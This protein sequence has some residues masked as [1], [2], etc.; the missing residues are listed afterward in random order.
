MSKKEGSTAERDLVVTKWIGLA[1]TGCIASNRQ[2]ELENRYTRAYIQKAI[3]LMEYISVKGEEI[4]LRKQPF[5]EMHYLG[6]G[7]IYGALWQFCM[8]HQV[9]V[10]VT[11]EDIPVLQETIEVCEYYDIN[12]YAL[13]STGSVMIAAEDGAELVKAM[14]QAGIPA[15]V[16]GRTTRGKDKIIRRDGEIGYLERT[17]GDELYQL[18]RKTPQENKKYGE[19]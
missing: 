17:I 10:H 12:P 4:V 3:R 1:G 5:Y 16:I 8:A 19:K 9:G 2:K 14:E 6:T 13:D 11:L 7:G 15:A 18:L